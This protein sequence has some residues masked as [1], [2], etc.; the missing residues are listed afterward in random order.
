MKLEE[1]YTNLPLNKIIS[2]KNKIS[3]RFI[4]V[5]LLAFLFIIFFLIAFFSEATFDT[6]DGLRHYMIS[7]YSWKH[8]ALF[9]DSWG[10]PFFT[11]ISSP[12]SQFGLLGINVFNIICAIVSS[13]LCFCIA[14][15]LNMKFPLVV[16]LLLCFSSI[17]FPTMNSGLTEPF[18][19][20][21]LILSIYFMFEE[22][23]LLSSIIVSFL[24]YVRSEGYLLLPLFGILFLYRRKIF[25]TPWLMFGTLTYSIIGYFYYHDFFWLKTQNPYTGDN[26]DLYGHGELLHFVTSY[27]RIFG[28]PLTIFLI[29]GFAFLFYRI[30]S[31]RSKCERSS[32]EFLPEEIILVYGSITVCFI[33]H[34]IFW[35]KGIVGSLGLIRVMAGVMPVAA[36]I[37]LRGLNLILL[38]AE[39]IKYLQLFV[40]IIAL[41]FIVRVPFYQNYFPYKP[42]PE[43]VV[44]KRACEWIKTSEYKWQKI[45]FLHSFI[46]YVLDLDI[47]DPNRSCEL[48][49]LYSA[50]KKWGI[51]TVP[52][53]SLIV[54]DAHYGA[55]E[56]RI[57]LDTILHDTNFR[58]LSIFKPKEEFIVLGGHKFSVYVFSRERQLSSIPIKTELFDM[59]QK[60]KLENE[61]TLSDEKSL[62]GKFSSKLS[63]KNE[64][65]ATIIKNLE[66]FNPLNKFS[67]KA[68]IFPSENLKDVFF[69]MQIEDAAGNNLSWEANEVKMGKVNENGW[70]NFET[71]FVPSSELI[72]SGNTMKLY[73]W[74]KAKKTFFVD[75]I[76]II[77]STDK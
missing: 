71:E 49:V 66:N 6:G 26:A 40:V 46:P 54:W 29:L 28:T 25:L 38:Q 64:F 57:P 32:N 20:L 2:I 65:S 74:N 21:I 53:R 39:K 19:S 68:K 7:R 67:I 55:N 69:V 45:Y 34:S 35:W 60:G 41:F 14:Q 9:L 62:S 31:K 22:K 48:W 24:P 30:F 37:G 5:A 77:Y 23:Y 51:N 10:K 11:L 58:L 43:Q 52:Y 59:E 17:Y 63:D 56:A 18:F 44:I 16:I 3:E 13:Y 73:F 8:P 47:Y 1:H 4:L 42:D 72:K 61:N 27:A 15:K 70:N 12:F 33:A 36:L 75:D 76:Q 50:I